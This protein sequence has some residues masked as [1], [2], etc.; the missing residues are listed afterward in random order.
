[1]TT[2]QVPD[3]LALSYEKLAK[4][5]GRD[6]QDYMLEALSSYLE[7]LADVR[8]VSERLGEAGR[9]RTLDEVE[10]NLGLAD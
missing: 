7:D 10:K 4:E 5:S 9:R 3:D 1:M 2:L 6:K 8:V